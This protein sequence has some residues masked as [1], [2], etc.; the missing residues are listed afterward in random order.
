MKTM[1]EQKAVRSRPMEAMAVTCESTRTFWQFLMRRREEAAAVEVVAVEEAEGVEVNAP[2]RP[3]AAAVM[4]VM[5]GCTLIYWP[6]T[7]RPGVLKKFRI[8]ARHTTP[9]AESVRVDLDRPVVAVV[10]AAEAAINVLALIRVAGGA[11]TMVIILA[12]PFG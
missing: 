10:V 4:A 2:A 11:I 12:I 6:H 7:R 5:S 9:Q 8:G 1:A 3:V